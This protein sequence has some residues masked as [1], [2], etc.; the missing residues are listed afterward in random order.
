MRIESFT[1]GVFTGKGTTCYDAVSMVDALR[2]ALEM[3]E[4]YPDALLAEAPNPSNERRIT[5]GPVLTY[6]G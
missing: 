1:N 4:R 5:V 2:K 3:A 6:S